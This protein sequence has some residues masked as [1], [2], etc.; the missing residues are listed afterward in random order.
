MIVC[1]CMLFTR[2][3]QIYRLVVGLITPKTLAGRMM[4]YV[5]TYLRTQ[6]IPQSLL[7]LKG[8]VRWFSILRQESNGLK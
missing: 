2:A 3:N 1:D 5:D 6:L 7:G 4:V 8:L